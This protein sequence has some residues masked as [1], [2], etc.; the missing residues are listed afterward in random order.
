MDASTYKRTEWLVSNGGAHS[1]SVGSQRG[2]LLCSIKDFNGQFL[3]KQAMK[4]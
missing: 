4:H 2:T 1:K 3:K